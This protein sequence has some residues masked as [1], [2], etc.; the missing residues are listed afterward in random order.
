MIDFRFRNRL[1]DNIFDRGRRNYNDYEFNEIKDSSIT[2]L[3]PHLYPLIKTTNEHYLLKTPRDVIQYSDEVQFGNKP[4]NREKVY[5]IINGAD[6]L[7]KLR[8]TGTDF[9][10]G[11]GFVGTC[12][13]NRPGEI[14]PLFVVCM[15]QILYRDNQVADLTI[16]ADNRYKDQGA[17][18]KSV[19]NQYL[20]EHT[21]DIIITGEIIKHLSGKIRLP[22]FA[23]I[24]AKKQFTETFI[25]Q[26][27]E[28]L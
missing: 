22:R 16:L 7:M 14:V 18:I 28:N 24:A 5:E 12:D 15:P 10:I 17:V 23:N 8:I 20:V 6:Y 2:L 21:G 27:V 9:Y 25:Q 13:I 3:N 1:F 26:C 11:K 4:V 19:V